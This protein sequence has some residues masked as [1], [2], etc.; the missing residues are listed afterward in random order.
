MVLMR[1]CQS[2]RVTALLVGAVALGHTLDGM[3]QTFELTSSAFRPGGEI[4]ERFTCQG[5]NISPPLRWYGAP[6]DT[7]SLALIVD[8]PD[9]P[10][11]AHPKQTWVHWVVYN[12][13]SSVQSFA[14]GQIPRE[15]NE[16]LNDW[17][18]AEYGG[19][20]PPVGRHRYFHK[21][22]ALDSILPDLKNP[23]KAAL[24]RAMEGHVLGKAEL[25]GLYSK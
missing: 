20:C 18:K 1:W 14:E 17:R 8:D 21:L 6:K 4:P 10:D 25:V 5:S 7:K 9:A 15:A 13:P 24:E 23:T 19:P 2:L 16:G 12:I 3:A 11:P 22:Y